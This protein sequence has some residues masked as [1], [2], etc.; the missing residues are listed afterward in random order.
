[1]SSPCC[2]VAGT[3][4]KRLAKLDEELRS[5]EHRSFRKLAEAFGVPG[6][7]SAI[8]RHKHR[9]LGIAGKYGGTSTVMVESPKDLPPVEAAPKS[10]PPR[11]KVSQGQAGTARSVPEVSQPDAARAR[12][13]ES[14]K[15][16]TSHE[17][18]VLHIVSQMATGTWDGPKEISE[19]AGSWGLDRDTVRRMA[20]EAALICRVD[21]GTVEERRQASM[22]Y[23]RRLYERAMDEADQPGEFDAA[24]KCLA[25][26]ATAQTGWDKAG[27]VYDDATK[28]TAI[29]G[30]PR[31]V[32]AAKRYVDAVQGVLDS[33]GAIAERVRARLGADVPLDVIAA[34]LAVV[35]EA[36]EERV[37]GA[38]QAP[39]L[40]GG[41]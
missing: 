22:G 9:C 39:A 23:W 20:A 26:A 17:E 10:K 27:G 34:V 37:R 2:K 18:R 31:F 7:K 13:R 40:P 21:R 29:F 41:A 30:D 28:V 14:A 25:V 5:P 32:E 15:D 38:A 24:S 3:L 4:G 35:D 19:L 6:Q 36:I 8:E 11:R 33:A 12:A 16:A 1:M